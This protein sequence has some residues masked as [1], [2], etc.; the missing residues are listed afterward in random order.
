MPSPEHP[1]LRWL[2]RLLLVWVVLIAARSVVPDP[3][4]WSALVPAAQAGFLVAAA[5]GLGDLELRALRDT[6][7]GRAERFLFAAAAGFGSLATATLFIGWA[8]GL[9]PAVVGP[10]LAGLAAWGAWRSLGPGGH[11]IAAVRCLRGRRVGLLEAILLGAGGAALGLYFLCCLAPPTFFDSMVYHLALPERF[12]RAGSVATD[13]DFVFSYFPLNMEMLY[14][15]GRVLFADHRTAT[16]LNFFVGL[17]LVLGAGCLGHR[18]GGGRAAVIAAAVVVLTPGFGLLSIVPKHDLALALFEV[19]A[20]LAW[21]RW[22][23]DR[24]TKALLL[25][26]V[27]G[28]FACGTKYAGVYFVAALAVATVLVALVREGDT[29]S[30]RSGGADRPTNRNAAAPGGPHPL[31]RP[32]VG[33]ALACLIAAAVFSPWWG[34]NLALTGN[35]VHPTLQAVFPAAGNL[36]PDANR[37]SMERG[38]RRDLGGL[39]L[40]PW[41]MTFH[42]NEFRFFAQIGPFYLALLP[43][44]IV[45]SRRRP[46]L[47][48]ILTA[49]AIALPLWWVTR[50]NTRYLLGCLVLVAA[51][52]A[53]VLV[54]LCERGPAWRVVL[55]GF[56]ILLLPVNLAAYLSVERSLFDVLGHV[57]GGE[58][59][60]AFLAQRLGYYP[61][62]RY[63][64]EQLPAEARILLVGE[65]RTYYLE[66]AVRVS[67]AHDRSL[68]VRWATQGATPR[69]F[70]EVLRRE[71]ITHLLV[72]R[73]EGERLAR[74]YAYYDFPDRGSRAAFDMVL[75]E[76]TCTLFAEGP[77]RVL[78][79]GPCRAPVGAGSRSAVRAD[80]GVVQ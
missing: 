45:F 44:L 24:E 61:A 8:G 15:L 50:P 13:P 22:W 62:A 29:V 60:H 25:A 30:S 32:V 2:P 49:A 53:A 46:E 26:G 12:A 54:R 17:L 6:A 52:A 19:A 34:R 57:L 65:T 72:N 69:G 78:A 20:F 47:I 1:V 59:G 14:T 10:P 27:L 51:G 11:L 18:F 5:I 55:G 58:D 3:L 66:R 80:P 73:R 56:L 70:M 64:N 67:S 79:V 33:A 35:P 31:L 40:A 74:G 37:I 39:L 48:L 23:S 63:I 4:L 9:R 43:A 38:G 41:D 16:L 77:V 21:C 76:G 71:G 28:G 42:P 36:N 7:A 75:R 68:P